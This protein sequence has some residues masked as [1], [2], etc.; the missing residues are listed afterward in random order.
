MRA[1][2]AMAPER[3]AFLYETLILKLRE[4]GGRAIH[5]AWT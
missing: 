4:I 5:H 1:F 2:D 3:L